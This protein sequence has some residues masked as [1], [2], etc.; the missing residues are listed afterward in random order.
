MTGEDARP[1]FAGF[2]LCGSPK[3]FS[4]QSTASIGFLFHFTFYIVF[5]WCYN[6]RDTAIPGE[7]YLCSTAKLKHH[8][9][10]TVTA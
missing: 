7:S 5:E 9:V 3:A 10:A 6:R 2:R 8:T 1:P 4:L